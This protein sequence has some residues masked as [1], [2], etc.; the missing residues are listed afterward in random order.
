MNFIL[1]LHIK[2]LK[3]DMIIILTVF[4]KQTICSTITASDLKILLGDVT[5]K[6]TKFLNKW[7]ILLTSNEMSQIINDNYE[8]YDYKDIVKYLEIKHSISFPIPFTYITKLRKEHIILFFKY[9]NLSVERIIRTFNKEQLKSIRH[10]S[11]ILVVNAGPGTGKTTTACA[12]TY[13]LRD[14]GVIFVSY[15]NAAVDVIERSM[16]DYPKTSSLKSSKL[17]NSYFFNTIDKVAGSINGYISE[18]FD[19]SIKDAC[20]K[21]KRDEFSC[22]HK[23]IIVDEAQDID[24][25][26]ADFIMSLFTYGDFDSLTVFGDPRQ[27]VNERCGKW[28]KNLWIKSGKKKEI[29]LDGNDI[30]LNRIGFTVSY[31]FKS[32]EMVD[33]VNSLSERRPELHCQLTI[34]SPTEEINKPII[35]YNFDSNSEYK[36]MNDICNF[37]KTKHEEENIPYSEFIIIGPS[38]ENENST[39]LF[40]R[41]IASFFRESDI[42]C[43]LFSEGSYESRGVLFSTIQ[44]SKGKEADYIFMF[45]MNN[46]PNSFSMIPFQEAESLIYV[47]HSR[48]RKQIYY[49]NNLKDM[50]LPRGITESQ[51][52]NM[53]TGKSFKQKSKE[54]PYSPTSEKSVTSLIKCFDFNKLMETNKL[55]VESKE[56]DVVFPQ[57][58]IPDDMSPEFFGTMIGIG[59]QMYSSKKL[60]DVYDRFIADEYIKVD[61][62]I[63]STIK[64]KETFINGID[65]NNNMILNTS[66]EFD[67]ITEKLSTF[68]DDIEM[69]TNSDYY[70]LTTILYYV[71]SGII[72]EYNGSYSFNLKKYFKAVSKIIIHNYGNVIECESQVNK[73]MICGRIDILTETAVI[74]LKV[75]TKTNECD[76]LQTFLYKA[77]GEFHD[78]KAVLINLRINETYIITSNRIL[79]YWLYLINN[80]NSIRE[81]INFT[82]YKIRKD[83]NPIEFPNNSF[84]IDT[85]FS[86]RNNE[87]F[88]IGIFNINDP[89]RSIVQTI[90]VSSDTLKFAKEWLTMSDDMFETSPSFKYIEKL[91]KRLTSLFDDKPSMYYY[92]CNV[93]HSWCDYADKHNVGDITKEI[94]VKNG[95]FSHN[96]VAP[97]LSDFYNSHVAFLIHQKHL[98]HHTALS[99]SLMLYTILK[100]QNQL[101]DN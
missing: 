40:S 13:K 80:Y 64:R 45:G 22:R 48:A 29:T 87:I 53:Y 83:S 43:K 14:E 59:I 50:T 36:I 95:I 7:K 2:M 17:D 6:E 101:N 68:N 33:L 94:A 66:L 69:M 88:E 62:S 42:P 98:A 16:Y 96:K 23:H 57:L 79:E 54:D 49:I 76:Y 100:C 91:F 78:K 32:Q 70:T 37:I 41:K 86:M 34:A 77:L 58:P 26:R 46:Y 74:E 92:I 67:R 71:S 47:S 31:R 19:H 18:T 10:N 99:D 4:R 97:K 75:K 81:Q 15:S 61:N 28:Y 1:K 12:K 65:E 93:D 11:G 52:L 60:P 73:N 21:I 90:N 35:S 8:E 5:V 63:Y 51:I 39:S 20:E 27:K 84:C 82:R 38:L 30:S 72:E 85:E 55:T 9:K 56:E 44:S 24:D 3:L 25:I 89:F